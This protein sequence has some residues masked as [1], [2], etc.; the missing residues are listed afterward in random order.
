MS[1]TVLCRASLARVRSLLVYRLLAQPLASPYAVRDAPYIAVRPSAPSI[2]EAGSLYVRLLNGFILRRGQ[3]VEG[4]GG[5]L[6]APGFPA[7]K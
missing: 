1:K 2:S 4:E 3:M 5:Q 7:G 6:Q